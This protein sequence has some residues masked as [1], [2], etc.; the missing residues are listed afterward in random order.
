MQ[1]KTSYYVT[2]KD[3]TV[4]QVL[5]Q[6]L[7]LEGATRLFGIPGGA[8]M[9]M[10]HDLKEQQDT[11]EY[12]I[13]RHETGAAYIADG[14]ARVTGKLGVVLVTSGPGATNALTGTMNAEYG[15]SPLLTIT[16][17]VPEK[18]FGMGYLQEG[19]DASLTI[20]D[21][22]RNAAGYSVVIGSASSFQTLF[23]QA[24]RNALS[25]PPRA[26]HVSLPNDIAATTL[27]EVRF[28]AR[29]HNYRTVPHS[30]S[31]DEVRQAFECLTRARLPLVF[32]GNGCRQ[33]LQGE[34]LGRLVAFTEKFGIPVMTSPNAKGIF[35]ESH[36][37][38]L[39]NYGIAGCQWPRYY[40]NPQLVDPGLW[41][42]YDALLVLG[43]TLGQ[44]ETNVWDPVLI[45]DGPLIQVDLEQ[46]VI[47]RAF[48]VELGIVGE[49]GAVL[50][51]LLE[52]GGQTAPDAA[53]VT[54]RGAFIARIKK[55]FSPFVS[56]DRR[57]SDASPIM[58]QAL[59]KCINELLPGGSHLFVDAGN[60][61]GWAMND[62][63]IDPPTQVHSSLAMGPMGFGVGAVI[64]GKL[65][66]PDCTCVA[67]VGDGAF[68]MHGSEV[69]MAA[70]YRI[71]AIWVVL[72]DNDL[73]MVS[74]GM[75]HF[76]PDPTTWKSYYK[77]GN[78]DLA[79]FAEG[80]GAAASV[81]RSPAE[82][83]Q[84]LSEAIKNADA[85]K[86][87]QVIVAHI[88]ADEM[89]LYYPS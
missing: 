60:C 81:V 12:F 37:L 41:P 68:M 66:A 67:I 83:K 65:G 20:N 57:D 89:P 8:S 84:A 29:P 75:N 79:K 69:S 48:P 14:Y 87:P 7:Q 56:P 16:G 86:Q 82:M 71:G 15:H 61:V 30:S 25:R 10:L 28:P 59:M 34:R 9:Q 27:S 42:H 63:E 70:H 2:L 32:L 50:D 33:A 54:A 31:P 23:T 39:R 47:A 46:S 80:L 55:T 58:P 5:L 72:F 1:E 19:V 43:S 77:V 76:F 49:T 17:E 24:L 36:P 74:Q 18:Y 45:P 44:L 62:L 11:F 4:S 51:D 38:S 53:E 52:L 21:I 35:P 40:L 64:G 22:Y 78:P 26:A 88:N 13:C 73:A 85:R 6:Y 3:K